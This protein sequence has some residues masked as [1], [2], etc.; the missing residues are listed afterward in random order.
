MSCDVAASPFNDSLSDPFVFQPNGNNDIEL[1]LSSIADFN[2][3]FDG[4]DQG[5]VDPHHNTS[6]AGSPSFEL[7]HPLSPEPANYYPN[8]FGSTPSSPFIQSIEQPPVAPLIPSPLR[9]QYLH[10]RSVS[11]PPDGAILHHHPDIQGAVTFHRDGHKLGDPPAK[12]CAYTPPIKK[13]KQSRHQPY[14][15]APNPPPTVNNRYRLRR[16]NTNPMQQRPPTSAP[17]GMIM[18]PP[19]PPSHFPQPPHV[20]YAPMMRE[21]PQPQHFV[22]SRVCT[23]APESAAIDPMLM[24]TPEPMVPQ[25]GSPTPMMATPMQSGRQSPANK[26]VVIKLDVD[27]L[28]ALI[29]EAV[30]KAVEGLQAVKK[31]KEVKGAATAE[32]EVGE[33]IV[34]VGSMEGAKDDAVQKQGDDQVMGDIDFTC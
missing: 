15:R 2:A 18:R 12:S 28:R 6:N 22:S 31:A 16:A 8:D 10:R 19:P 34:I 26:A 3:G 7:G 17:P 1:D 13:V 32:S 29:A 4:L 33:N 21:E 25:M 27:E 23:P 14:H 11:E 20:P 24:T 9:H 5:S 30:Q